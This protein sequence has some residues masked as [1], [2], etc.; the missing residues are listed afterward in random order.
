VRTLG[1]PTPTDRLTQ[2]ALHQVLTPLF[3]ADFSES[4]H[5]FR[6]GRNAHQAIKATRRYVAEGRGVVVDMDS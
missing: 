3:G 1:M 2:Q 5:G 4:S 6:T